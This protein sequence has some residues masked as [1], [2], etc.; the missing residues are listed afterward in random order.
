MKINDEKKASMAAQFAA[1]TKCHQ[2]KQIMSCP[3]NWLCLDS[4][5]KDRTDN[6]AAPIMPCE[7]TGRQTCENDL[8]DNILGSTWDN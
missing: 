5:V 4:S 8:K 2:L 7:L 3:V 6:C 1:E